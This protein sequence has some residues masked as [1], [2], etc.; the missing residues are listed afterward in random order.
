VHFD[1]QVI[2][3]TIPY[4][5]RGLLNTLL[6]T[7]LGIILSSVLAL[8]CTPLRLSQ[9]RFLKIVFSI[10]IDI[11]RNTPIV[12]Q[13]FYLY[14]ALPLIGIKVSAF[15][16]GLI[17]LVLHYNAYNIEVLRSGMEAVPMGFNEA[18]MALGFT[19]IQRLRLV[20][21]PLALRISLPALVNN[22]VSLLKNT[23]LVSIIGVVELT[24][25]A[26]D[27]IADKFNYLEMYATIAVVYL[28]LI[29]G[30]TWFLRKIESRYAIVT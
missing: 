1:I 6:L 22:Y 25:V 18:G 21:L 3:K 4:L 12:A 15:G 8:V 16:C 2:I 23:A 24:F 30:L 17:A 13:I 19:H 28:V 29:F 11:F 26:Q 27:V 20:I 9:N 14:F 10:Y 7:F 5:T